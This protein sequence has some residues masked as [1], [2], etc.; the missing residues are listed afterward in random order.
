MK[1]FLILIALILAS[2][3]V[4]AQDL[5]KRRAQILN[6]ID[7]EINEI[8]R[9]SSQRKNTAELLLRRAEL[10]LEKARLWRE[11]EN[12]DFLAIP[13][14]KRRKLKKENYFRTSTKF[15]NRANNLAVQLLRKYPRYSKKGEAY[16]ILGYN[17]K[18]A[19][20]Q[21]T[22]A[23]Y[24]ARAGQTTRDAETKIKTQITLAEVY[25]N[26]KKFSKA[27]PLY[28]SALSKHKDKW[29]TKDSFNLAWS[30]Y[31]VNR[32]DKAIDKMKEVY[33]YSKDNRFIDMSRDVER[34][35]GIFY[36]TSGKVSEG[37]SFYRKIGENF[38]EK[39][40][41]IAAALNQ[42]GQYTK[43]IDV[44]ENALKNTKDEDERI[45]IYVEMLIVYDKAAKNAD[46]LA[47]SNKLVGYWKKKKLNTDQTN[48]MNFQMEKKGAQIQRQVISKTYRRVRKVRLLKARQAV[49]YF[50]NL[51][52][53]KPEKGDEYN[54]LIAET[55][56]IVGYYKR[57]FE[58]Y[59]KSFELAKASP[60]SKFKSLAMEGLLAALAKR[61]NATYAN[62]V[63]VYES[64]LET[65]PQG[66]KAKG[67]YPRLFNNYFDQ[68]EY[69]K[70]K[71]V[72]DRYTNSYPKD[73]K[74]QEAMIAKLMDVNRQQGD[75][76]AVRNWITAVEAK[77]Y[78]V[79]SKFKTKLQ[80]LLTTLQIENVQTELG[81]GNKQFALVGYHKILNDPYST[82]RSKINAKYNLSAL[83][84]ELGDPE[85]AYKWAFES[86]KE[87]DTKDVLRFSSSF[88][89][90]ANYLFT[91][92]DFEKSAN[93]SGYFVE[94]VC[95]S[96]FAKKE[97]SF[98]NGVFIYLAAGEIDK[99]I[100]LVNRGK[101]CGIPRVTIE[102][103]EFE[104][105]REL[106]LAKE[107]QR[108][109]QYVESLSKSKRYSARMIDEY[110]FLKKLNDRF[111]NTA[112]TNEYMKK[113]WSLFY[114]AR[115]ENDSVSISSLDY[116]A[117][118]LLL[119]M[120][121]TADQLLKIEYS[122]PQE[123]FE[124]TLAKKFS[125]LEKL[126]GEASKVQEVGSG[127][128]I[129]NSFKLLYDVHLA[130]AQRI[131]DFK[132]ADKS[133][134][135]VAAFKKDMNAR[136]GEKLKQSAY[137]YKKEA[138]KAITANNILNQN[139]FYFQNGPRPIKYFGETS[140]LLMD[141]G[142]DK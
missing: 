78:A 114:K 70:A 41:T 115:R 80:E 73:F 9:L 30:Y 72:L 116:F 1:S 127:V 23:K 40:L 60:K 119:T 140:V 111:N 130:E 27:I 120:K 47:V 112:K 67:I 129:V 96:K 123:V 31:Q 122:F 59:K 8:N 138:H 97:V 12:S 108:Y 121:K 134:E 36:A 43:A 86:L 11:K 124:K 118:S 18:E 32:F 82:N 45:R 65:F 113:A 77:K 17:A 83:Y 56:F 117:D 100:E 88:I 125:L 91:S 50:E 87:M 7:E 14:D 94:K 58:G 99:A 132:P 33:R 61:S 128:G 137:F 62:N 49:N 110:L 54:F 107:W 68:K 21:K 55:S 106:R 71:S 66:R 28:E 74:T 139:N 76:V 29:W 44:L 98:K 37:V 4:G 5:E 13:S 46:H 90:I 102:L 2:T 84:F 142:G 89:T 95:K 101:T 16:Y 26:E 136:F 53:T 6:I 15:F 92:L 63:Y 79:S 34:D 48:L 25:Y 52:Q 126:I 69:A 109:E 81:K 51:A 57:A 103:S 22:A 10:N 3:S 38:S 141:R 35:L 24:L 20:K 64:Y 133:P 105:M 75:N 39:L 85:N 135:Y 131:F 93:L 42:Q 19:N 104:I